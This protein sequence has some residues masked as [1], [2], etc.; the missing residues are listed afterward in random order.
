MF[1][2]IGFFFERWHIFIPSPCTRFAGSSGAARGS[3][4]QRAP[5]SVPPAA[6]VPACEG[7]GL[8]MGI[9]KKGLEDKPDISSGA[10]TQNEDEAV[11]PLFV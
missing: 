4:L 11:L 3:N 10:G 5:R 1:D 6:L 8:K 7:G 2:F 9:L